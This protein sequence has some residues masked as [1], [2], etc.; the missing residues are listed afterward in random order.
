[1]KSFIQYIALLGILLLAAC[2]DDDD[3]K[4]S[5][6]TEGLVQITEGYALGAGV[7]VELWADE[8][9]FTG[10]NHVYAVLYDST[11]GDLITSAGVTF[12]PLMTMSTSMQH[13][14]PVV[15]PDDTAVD[16]LFAGAIFF[17]MPST[18]GTWSMDIDI[19]LASGKTGTASFDELTVT[20][21]DDAHMT[22]FTTDNSESI[23]VTYDFPNGMAVGTNDFDVFIYE[24]ESA[25]VFSPVDVYT[26]TAD[27]EMP[28]MGHGSSNNVDPTYSDTDQCYEGEINFTMTGD[29]TINL[30][31][32]RTDDEDRTVSFDV[33][34]D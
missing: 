15:N 16:D 24:K 1:M 17:I 18:G 25:T 23:F 19:T 26:I 9:L 20:E 5:D 7:L 22:S 4:T 28:S 27:P 12:D 6:P 3:K 2:S 13:T 30:D 32:T 8:S 14:C 33:T 10:Y 21:P 11:D 29:W 31:L 34:L